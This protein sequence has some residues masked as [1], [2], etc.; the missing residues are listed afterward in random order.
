MDLTDT[1]GVIWNVF[2]DPTGKVHYVHSGCVHDHQAHG[3]YNDLME[4]YEEAKKRGPV[5]AT[6]PAIE[7]NGD[8]IAFLD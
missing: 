5:F 2:Q 4:C 3:P 8:I 7:D 1:Y 6:P